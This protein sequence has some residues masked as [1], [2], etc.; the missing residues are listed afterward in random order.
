[1]RGRRNS[2]CRGN[3]LQLL[4]GIWYMGPD[5]GFPLVPKLVTLNDAERRIVAE[6]SH[7]FTETRHLGANC[8]T[9]V[10]VRPILPATLI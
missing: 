8:V 2:G 7:Y 9:V 3:C 10:K 6:I 1:M 5:M 4:G